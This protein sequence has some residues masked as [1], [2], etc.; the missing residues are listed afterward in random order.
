MLEFWPSGGQCLHPRIIRIENWQ[1]R[2]FVCYNSS[3][4]GGFFVNL[5][6]IDEI[7]ALLQRHGFRF[8]KSKGQ[9]FLTAAWV[10]QQICTSSEIDTH[11]GVLE[12]GPG[13]GPP[14]GPALPPCR[15]SGLRRGGYFPSS[16]PG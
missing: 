16:R 13:I 12:I 14:H 1:N 7:K 8:S 15:Q 6:N 4:K 11:C 3:T 5:C 10:P 2:P 9:N